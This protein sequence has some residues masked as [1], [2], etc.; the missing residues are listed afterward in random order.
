MKKAGDILALFESKYREIVFLQNSQDFDDF[1]GS[2]GKGSEGFFDSDEDEMIDFLLQW[3]YGDNGEEST[4][5]PWGTSDTTYKKRI[6]SKLYI[7]TY[8][9]KHGYA[10][11]VEVL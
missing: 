1:S 5:P 3:D 9:F 10:G 8:N 11:L 4:N 6:G 2:G 7:L